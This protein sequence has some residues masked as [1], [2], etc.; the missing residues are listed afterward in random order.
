MEK[1]VKNPVDIEFI[2]SF[3]DDSSISIT[4]KLVDHLDGRCFIDLDMPER[5]EGFRFHKTPT[6]I[7]AEYCGADGGGVAYIDDGH[8]KIND[9]EYME[10]K[11]GKHPIDDTYNGCTIHGIAFS[12]ELSM[13]IPM[14]AYEHIRH[15]VWQQI[16][17]HEANREYISEV[18]NLILKTTE[19]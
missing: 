18:R 10:D 16:K 12:P 15:F 2:R 5:L 3:F 13:E 6:G 1:T 14:E 19:K 11:F 8:A 9:H 17:I 4:R 7:T